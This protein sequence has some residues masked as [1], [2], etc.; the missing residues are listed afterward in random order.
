VVRRGDVVWADFGPQR[1][2]NIVTVP[3][4][5]LDAE[6]VGHLDSGP[7]SGSTRRSATPST[8]PTDHEHPA[9][10]AR[11]VTVRGQVFAVAAQGMRRG[12]PRG[13]VTFLLTNV[14]GSARLWDE[15]PD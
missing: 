1:D 5:L 6:P 7:G 9:Q 10:R 11:I 13:A 4:T 3:T 12:P 2:D 14:E 15:S 8:S